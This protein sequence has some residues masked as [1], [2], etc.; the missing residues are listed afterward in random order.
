MPAFGE[1]CSALRALQLSAIMCLVNSFIFPCS[2]H[3]HPHFNY[4]ETVPRKNKE[5]ALGHEGARTG[6]WSS[7]SKPCLSNASL[8]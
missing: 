6:A 2:E 4:E 7:E 3:H 8:G 5:A 1:R